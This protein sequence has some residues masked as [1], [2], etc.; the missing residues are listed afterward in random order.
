MVTSL[1]LTVVITFDIHMGE[2]ICENRLTLEVES[3]K[4]IEY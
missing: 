4:V 1:G 2:L 3:M